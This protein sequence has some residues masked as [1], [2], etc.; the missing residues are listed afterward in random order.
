MRHLLEGGVFAFATL[1]SMYGFIMEYMEHRD[2]EFENTYYL[3][4]IYL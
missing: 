3:I 4:V 1:C 2:C